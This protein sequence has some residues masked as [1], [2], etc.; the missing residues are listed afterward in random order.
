[1]IRGPAIDEPPVSR[2]PGE[3]NPTGAAAL[4]FAHRHKLAAPA[5]DTAEIT[6]HRISEHT[7]WFALFTEAGELDFMQDH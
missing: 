4:S 2:A 5:I 6:R 7:T 1:V 3:N